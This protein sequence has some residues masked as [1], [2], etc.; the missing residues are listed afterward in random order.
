VEGGDAA[1]GARCY[2]K[3]TDGGLMAAMEA[4]EFVGRTVTLR[5]DGPVNVAQV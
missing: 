5:S 1:G 4:E 2:A 3:S